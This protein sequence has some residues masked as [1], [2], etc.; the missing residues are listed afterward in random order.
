MDAMEVTVGAGRAGSVTMVG[1]AR[2]KLAEGAALFALS[3]LGLK[4]VF[5]NFLD[6]LLEMPEGF[7]AFC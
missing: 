6:L 2:M 4:R 1:L 7:P 3:F 5:K